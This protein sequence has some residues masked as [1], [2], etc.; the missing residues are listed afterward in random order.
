MSTRSSS[1]HPDSIERR[2]S[3]RHKALKGGR[4]VFNNL[5]SS[6]DCIIRDRSESGARLDV[7]TVLGIPDRFEL[8][9]S[10]GSRPRQCRIR[11][12]TGHALGVRFTD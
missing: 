2:D 5:A 8:V 10:D 9:F 6:I 7:D 4:I 12:K 3:E 11:W 1:A